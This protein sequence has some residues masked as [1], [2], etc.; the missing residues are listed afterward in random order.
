M[1][2]YEPITESVCVRISSFKESH[3]EAIAKCESEGGYLFHDI[4]QEV[5]VRSISI[6]I[7]IS[8]IFINP[9]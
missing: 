6:F 9:V 7:S 5:H 8:L 1:D 4:N 2:N 3:E